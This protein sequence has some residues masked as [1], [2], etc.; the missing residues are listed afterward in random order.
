MAE[1]LFR[2]LNIVDSWLFPEK[3]TCLC[4]ESALG[5]DEQ[6]GPVPRLHTGA[7]QT[8]RRFSNRSAARRYPFGLC[9][10]SL[11]RPAA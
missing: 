8:R 10:F 11:C 4:C 9:R 3:I 5:D 6:D 1:R 7:R 2:L